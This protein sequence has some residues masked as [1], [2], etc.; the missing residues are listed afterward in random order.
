MAYHICSPLKWWP[1]LRALIM[2]QLKSIV[3]KV[4]LKLEKLVENGVLV[5]MISLK[6]DFAK[7][8]LKRQLFN[9]DARDT[10]VCLKYSSGGKL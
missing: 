9:I 1:G 8:T 3:R 5:R 10:K 6:W 2:K 4:S 7:L